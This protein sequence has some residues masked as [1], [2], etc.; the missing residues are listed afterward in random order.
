MQSQCVLQQGSAIALPV[1]DGQFDCAWS[2]NM[3]MNVAD[4]AAF[5]T[6]VAR[7]LKPGVLFAFEAVLEGN[8]QPVHLPAFWASRAEN[9]F[10]VPPH[11]LE[12]LLAAAGLE[13]AALDDTSAQVVENSRKRRAVIVAHHPAALSIHVTVPDDVET[14]MADAVRRPAMSPLPGF[15]TASSAQVPIH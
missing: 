8:G 15:H 3:M 6:E 13:P 7:V 11:E 12:R 4:K 2:Q 9:N 14:R 1:D 5:F 10:L